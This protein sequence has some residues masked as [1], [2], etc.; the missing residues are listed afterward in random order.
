M[1][2]KKNIKDMNIWSYF[3][4]LTPG[5]E[6]EVDGTVLYDDL[7][8]AYLVPNVGRTDL[9]SLD[10]DSFFYC[11][12]FKD[13]ELEVYTKESDSSYEYID[14]MGLSI[15]DFA[16]SPKYW[17]NVYAT[18][19]QNF[20]YQEAEEIYKDYVDNDASAES[21]DQSDDDMYLHHLT[22][23]IQN[24]NL[25]LSD[26]DSDWDNNLEI[27]NAYKKYITDLNKRYHKYFDDVAIE[28][29]Y[30]EEDNCVYVEVYLNDISYQAKHEIDDVVSEIRD[31]ILN[32]VG[33]DELEKLFVS[34]GY[35]N[36]VKE[37]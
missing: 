14:S 24:I 31:D 4:K 23:K 13:K 18:E 28:I 36:L 29:N 7:G 21:L 33:I 30:S 22:Y 2:S 3:K 12:N 11:Y 16:D 25:N 32:P 15:G 9:Y 37:D 6:A 27:K 5:Q 10:G 35:V 1:D 34:A 19:L 26:A 17:V 8:I 20:G